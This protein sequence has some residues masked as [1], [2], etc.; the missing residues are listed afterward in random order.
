MDAAAELRYRQCRSCH[1]PI[2]FARHHRTN[3][4]MPLEESK[5][6]T[7]CLSA[8]EKGLTAIPAEG[9]LTT[10]MSHHATCPDAARWRKPRNGDG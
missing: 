8:S 10:Y 2:I 4:L 9:T 3:A 1:K 5:L 7:F 6:G